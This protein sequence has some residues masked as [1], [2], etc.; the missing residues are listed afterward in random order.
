MEVWTP[1]GAYLIRSGNYFLP[2]VEIIIVGD[3]LWARAGLLWKFKMLVPYNAA[4][5]CLKMV[6]Q[7]LS[8]PGR[9]FCSRDELWTGAMN[10]VKYVLRNTECTD[11]WPPRNAKAFVTI[12]W[13]CFGSIYD[14]LSWSGAY[15][16]KFYVPY[17]LNYIS[18]CMH[19]NDFIWIKTY[20]YTDIW[21]TVHNWMV[22]P[23]NI[24]TK[25]EIVIGIPVF[26]GGSTVF[27][28]SHLDDFG[29]ADDGA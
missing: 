28:L 7:V 27:G 4:K 18:T 16:Y 11:S 29:L 26:L 25:L 17:M 19:I 8:Q 10:L 24:P 22:C 15:A 2:E 23:A 1:V 12:G 14:V 21:E 20:S 13:T 3:V 5:T 9:Y 6:L